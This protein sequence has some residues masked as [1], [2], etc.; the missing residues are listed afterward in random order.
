MVRGV[1][2]KMQDSLRRF[3]AHLSPIVFIIYFIVLTQRTGLLNVLN[4][5]FTNKIECVQQF[6]GC[7]S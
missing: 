7:K 6:Q 2:Q 1:P 5:L 3:A 4:V